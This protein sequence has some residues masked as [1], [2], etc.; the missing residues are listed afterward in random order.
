MLRSAASGEEEF[1]V[2]TDRYPSDYRAIPFC[3]IG[4]LPSPLIGCLPP[5]P[6]ILL[7]IHSDSSSR[8]NAQC[9]N[10]LVGLVHA[11]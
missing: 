7:S 6:S 11:D 8:Y 1:E 3:Y 2:T 5:P 10:V 4:S 9:L